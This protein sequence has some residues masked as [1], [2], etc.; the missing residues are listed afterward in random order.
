[1]A[2]ITKKQKQQV[3]D[4]A[5]KKFIKNK[6]FEVAAALGIILGIIFLPYLIGIGLDLIF[7]FTDSTNAFGY[8]CLGFLVLIALCFVCVIGFLLWT[9][10]IVDLFEAI[11]FEIS[12]F[13]E[14]NWKKAYEQA[15]DDLKIKSGKDSFKLKKF[16]KQ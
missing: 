4:L 16:Y 15:E 8:W 9:F 11:I 6:A 12:F 13:I 10:I 3:R 5:R 7:A 2:R 14:R 1:M